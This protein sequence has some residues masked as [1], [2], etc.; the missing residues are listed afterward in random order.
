MRVL[1]NVPGGL[2]GC[3]A[4]EAA[5]EPR[6]YDQGDAEPLRPCSHTLHHLLARLSVQ[7]PPS[8]FDELVRGC[9]PLVRAREVLVQRVGIRKCV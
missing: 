5:V 1:A 7:L 9:G 4:Q 6:L 8:G 2:S 3:Q